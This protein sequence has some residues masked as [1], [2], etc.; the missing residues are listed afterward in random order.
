MSRP[1]VCCC[2]PLVLLALT[3]A[4]AHPFSAQLKQPARVVEWR[5]QI[6]PFRFEGPRDLL[7]DLDLGSDR[8]RRHREFRHDLV[9]IWASSTADWYLIP[10]EDPDADPA[11]A[12]ADPSCP[13][14]PS[15][16]E[17]LPAAGEE[18]SG[19]AALPPARSAG[20]AEPR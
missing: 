7:R 12:C 13:D 11:E 4:V 10:L 3:A 5:R 2:F 18:A 1:P 19:Q 6:E 17:A 15:A 9:R 14:A 16:S 20:P 8:H